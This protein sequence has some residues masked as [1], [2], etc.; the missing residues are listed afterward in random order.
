LKFWHSDSSNSFMQRLKQ[1][2]FHK[3]AKCNSYEFL[4][5]VV[6]FWRRQFITRVWHGFSLM[7]QSK[8]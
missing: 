4:F 7:I 2:I 8:P 6:Y 5:S 3:Q 1:Y